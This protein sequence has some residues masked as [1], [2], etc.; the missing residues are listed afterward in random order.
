MLWLTLLNNHAKRRNAQIIMRHYLQR[1][2]M[3]RA[4]QMPHLPPPLIQ[5]EFELAFGV[6]VIK[7][8]VLSEPEAIKLT[9]R[10]QIELKD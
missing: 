4:K 9:E 3:Q 10:I 5:R 6:A 7:A 2:C 8:V 1:W